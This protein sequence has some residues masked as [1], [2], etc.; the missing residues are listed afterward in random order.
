MVA[1]VVTLEEQY[2]SVGLSPRPPDDARSAQVVEVVQR[3]AEVAATAS[4][5][6][7]LLVAVA[8]ATV[9]GIPAARC[10][11]FA[12]DRDELTPVG[13]VS[14]RGRVM[15]VAVPP[16]PLDAV[17]AL[18]LFARSRVIGVSDAARSALRSLDAEGAGSLLA[19][20]LVA[21]GRPLGAL[22]LVTDVPGR[23]VAPHERR[24]LET[25]AALTGAGLQR[26]VAEHRA[27]VAAVTTEAA[28]AL[29]GASSESEVVATVGAAIET[30]W[31]GASWR[32]LSEEV[33]AGHCGVGG[34]VAVLPLRTDTDTFGVVAVSRGATAAAPTM[35]ELDTGRIVA[36][37]AAGALARVRAG[38]RLRLRLHEAE[39]LARLSQVVA[40][41][42]GLVDAV[43]EVNRTLPPDFG[44]KLR[45][46]SI[47]NAKLREA[48]GGRMPDAVE[49]EA[50][51]SWRAVLASG[52]KLRCRTVQAGTVLVPVANRNKVHGALRVA[53]SG[54]AQ[55]PADHLLLAIGAAC[56]EVVHR[57]AIRG[58]M[59]ESERRLA[60]AAE[61]DRIAQDLHDSVGQL[62][63]GM[64]MRLAQHL[65]EAPDKVWRARLEELLQMAG[66]GNREIRQSVYALLFLEAR[67]SGL[68]SSLRELCSRFEVTTGLPVR[69]QHFGVATPLTPAKE[70]A[71]F[72]SAHEALVNAERHARASM[73]TVQLAFADDAVSLSVRD[74]GVGLGHRDP[75]NRSGHFGIRA[76]QRRAEEA[77]GEVRVTNAA[78]RGVLVEV[79]MPNAKGASRAVGTR[80]RRR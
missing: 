2:R 49:L 4:A 75:F 71:L 42:G 18:R 16:I 56:A 69:F 47:A 44:V 21:E 12:V 79:R 25:I 74:D 80:R 30:L 70:E 54:H 13:A 11:A 34:S 60:I 46:V 73:L 43:R 61:R 8:K 35:P 36:T 63:V 66:R 40:C 5:V 32:V 78:P 72:R 1:S 39:V 67:Q 51:R 50:V 77:G 20:P 15:P 22:V 52:G 10:N 23:V 24:L 58:H 26:V 7:D 45:S 53:T 68:V 9:E 76:M 62:V 33:G 48:V 57:A 55:A 28:L 6:D 3:V 19:A 64:G 41:S 31:P 14:A 38:E 37:A 65:A 29:A 59:A 17:A 27:A